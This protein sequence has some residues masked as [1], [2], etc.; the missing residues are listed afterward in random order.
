MPDVQYKARF[1]F[2]IPSRTLQNLSKKTVLIALMKSE[3]KT[4]II[5][6]YS[7]GNMRFS[8]AP[9]EVK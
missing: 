3:T 6:N 7:T 2:Y 5:A 8:L 4:I 1:R 9:N